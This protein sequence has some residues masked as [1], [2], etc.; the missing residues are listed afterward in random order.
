MTSAGQTPVP[1]ILEKWFPHTTTPFIAN[2]PMYPFADAGLATAV[3]SAGGFGKCMS[4]LS[5]YM[6]T[7]PLCAFGLVL[8][9]F[10][11][12]LFSNNS[13]CRGQE[14]RDK[15]KIWVRSVYY[16]SLKRIR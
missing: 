10:H 13:L 15:D 3:T 11:F 14:F 2:A 6:H 5:S 8:F 7:F 12:P 9:L 4:F 16:Y 1:T